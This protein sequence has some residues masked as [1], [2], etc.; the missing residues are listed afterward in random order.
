MTAA[1]GFALVKVGTIRTRDNGREAVIRY[2]DDPPAI[3]PDDEAIELAVACREAFAAKY[4][5]GYC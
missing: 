1:G 2:G 3:L 4:K 5:A